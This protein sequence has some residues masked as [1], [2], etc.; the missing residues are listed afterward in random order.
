M[1]NI[2]T[3][4]N[5]EKETDWKESGRNTVCNLP[6]SWQSSQVDVLEERDGEG[7]NPAKTL[8]VIYLNLDCLVWTKYL[9]KE[10]EKEEIRQKHHV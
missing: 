7:R 8:Y 6:K 2:V 3:T 10:T 1:S 4:K 9:E 5:E